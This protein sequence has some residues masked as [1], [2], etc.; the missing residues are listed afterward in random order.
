[1]EMGADIHKLDSNGN[2]GLFRAVLDANQ[3]LP[4][5]NFNT[6]EVYGGRIITG[7]LRAD[8]GRIF[9]LLFAHGANVNWIKPELG[10]SVEMLYGKGPVSEFWKK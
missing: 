5:C 9:D 7:Q 6:G 8:L 10:M 2:D 1:I 3:I 4:S